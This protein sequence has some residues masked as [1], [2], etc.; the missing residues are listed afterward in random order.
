VTPPAPATGY[1]PLAAWAGFAVLCGY[2]APALGLA[3]VLLRKRDA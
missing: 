2:A 1:F 3:F